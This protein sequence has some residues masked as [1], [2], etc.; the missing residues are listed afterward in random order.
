MLLVVLLMA[1]GVVFFLATLVV[2]QALN[3]IFLSG[4]YLYATTGQVPASLDPELVQS[5]F[6]PK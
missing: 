5:A 6:K 1:A 4:V 2:L 3:T